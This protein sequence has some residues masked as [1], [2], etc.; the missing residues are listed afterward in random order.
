MSASVK[1][2]VHLLSLSTGSPH[3]SA[4]QS[5]INLEHSW[6]N[7]ITYQS[8]VCGSGL[9]IMAVVQCHNSEQGSELW[10]LEWETGSLRLVSLVVLARMLY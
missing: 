2:E 7:G 1:L 10:V 8:A 3:P 4:V 6:G 9:A 5:V